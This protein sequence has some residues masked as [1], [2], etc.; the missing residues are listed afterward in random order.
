MGNGDKA[1]LQERGKGFPEVLMCSQSWELLDGICG[2]M[3]LEGKG[4]EQQVSTLDIVTV[5]LEDWTQKPSS[6]K[7]TPPKTQH[8]N[9]L[10]TLAQSRESNMTSSL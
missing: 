8:K 9:V 5:Q 2:L 10:S 4:K 3:A 7:S 6:A 1:T